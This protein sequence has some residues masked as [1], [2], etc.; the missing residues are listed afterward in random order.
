MNTELQDNGSNHVP[1]LPKR[2]LND[3][4]LSSLLRSLPH[5]QAS[6]GFEERVKRRLREGSPAAPAPSWWRR[7]ARV[8]TPLLAAAL[9]GFI[10]GPDVFRHGSEPRA[11]APDA[12]GTAL[13]AAEESGMQPMN[14]PRSLALEPSRSI[15]SI[16]PAP[17]AQAVSNAAPAGA[18]DP[19]VQQL[20]REAARIR[21]QLD[22]LR[23]QKSEA[24][25][26]VLW[27][28]EDGVE[29]ELDLAEFVMMLERSANAAMEGPA[30]G[31]TALGTRGTTPPESTTG[32]E[33]PR[34]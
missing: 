3:P 33:P 18:M 8:A 1:S 28:T 26:R 30:A 12:G 25:P 16:V 7:S 4:E 17:Q 2:S 20:R 27:T 11:A 19:R 14:P 13:A 21:Q 24:V 31:P 29:V 9:L 34:W 5:E 15:P 6:L 23:R 10:F 32:S 22:E